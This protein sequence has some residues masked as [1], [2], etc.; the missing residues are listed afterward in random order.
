MGPTSKWRFPTWSDQ[1]RPDRVRP[2]TRGELRD[3]PGA[4]E[5]KLDHREAAQ[6]QRREHRIAAVFRQPARVPAFAAPHGRAV[7][8]VEPE[9]VG[10]SHDVQARPVPGRRIHAASGAGSVGDPVGHVLSFA[11]R[12]LEQQDEVGDRHAGGE[13]AGLEGI[14]QLD[15]GRRAQVHVERQDGEAIESTARLSTGRLSMTRRS[16]P[17]ASPTS[18]PTRRSVPAPLRLGRAT[19]SG[20]PPGTTRNAERLRH[21]GPDRTS[22]PRARR[23]RRVATT[24]RQGAN[25]GS[26]PTTAPCPHAMAAGVSSDKRADKRT[27]LVGRCFG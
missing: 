4:A 9:R 19:T 18:L 13:G 5:G 17:R 11:D 6:R 23:P 27:W 14:D 12:L 2:D 15:G 26:A 21:P 24:S 10:D 3:P 8:Q 7:E 20:P 1:A 25:F 22:G 16:P